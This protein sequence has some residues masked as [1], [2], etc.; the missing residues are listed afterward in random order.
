MT[1]RSQDTIRLCALFRESNG[2]LSYERIEQEMGRPR[3]EIRNMILRVR[4]YLERD[5]GV[6]FA[7]ERNVGYRRLSDGEKVQSS[8][9]FRRRI[10]RSAI[11]G[12]T[13]LDAVADFGAL[14]K[15]EQMYATLRKRLFEEV[16]RRAGEG[17]GHDAG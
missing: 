6:V 11:R 1:Q 8:E 7:T 2:T 13:R 15:E 16:Q 9:G 3:H 17:L 5:E 4:N 10:R 14:S 12:S